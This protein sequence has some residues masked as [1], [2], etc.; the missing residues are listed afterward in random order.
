MGSGDPN[1]GP[2]FE[3]DSITAVIVGGT[4]LGG[5]RGGVVGTM[6]GVF[7]VTVLNNVLNLLDVAAWYQQIIK[8]LILLLAVSVYHRRD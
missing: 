7:L 8:G 2:G 3:L 1:I 5:G 4:V 6:G